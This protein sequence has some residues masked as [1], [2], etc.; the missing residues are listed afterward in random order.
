MSLLDLTMEKHVKAG[1]ILTKDA[2]RD[3]DLELWSGAFIFTVE[4]C[5][6]RN[7]CMAEDDSRISFVAA[8]VSRAGAAEM[9]VIAPNWQM[10]ECR[11]VKHFGQRRKRA[12]A[13]ETARQE[14]AWGGSC[15]HFGGQRRSVSDLRD[16]CVRPYRCGG[17]CKGG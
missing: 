7:A 16:D 15:L 6:G 12:A 3:S 4:W 17:A 11:F 10:Y 1:R 13:W 9:I 2:F 8:Y 5:T 14:D